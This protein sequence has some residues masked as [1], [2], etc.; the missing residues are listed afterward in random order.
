MKKSEKKEKR[1]AVSQDLFKDNMEFGLDV[2]FSPRVEAFPNILEGHLAEVGLH[3][4]NSLALHLRVCR[5]IEG[6]RELE[7]GER[8]SGML[9]LVHFVVVLLSWASCNVE[10]VEIC[11]EGYRV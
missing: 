11:L 1:Q 3:G 10:H 5:A 4:Q 2:L 8:C 9:V 7:I 6:A